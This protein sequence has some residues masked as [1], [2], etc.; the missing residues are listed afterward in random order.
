MP[1][2]FTEEDLYLKNYPHKD[3]LVIRA[4]VGINSVPFLGNDIGRILVDNGSAADIIFKNCYFAMGFKL[5]D[6]TQ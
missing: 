4:I 2:T 6:L 1:I 3:P 5:E